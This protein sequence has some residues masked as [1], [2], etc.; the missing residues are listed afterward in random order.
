MHFPIFLKRPLVSSACV[1][2]VRNEQDI[3]E[4]F[5]RHN[6]RFFDFMLILDHASTDATRRILSQLSNELGNVLVRDIADPAQRQGTFVTDALHRLSKLARP[7]IVAFLDADEFIGVDDRHDFLKRFRKLRVGRGYRLPWKTLIPDPQAASEGELLDRF[8]LVR[9]RDLPSSYKVLIRLGGRHYPDL[10]IAQGNHKAHRDRK[11][12]S[13]P[14]LDTPVIFHIPVRNSEQIMAKGVLSWAAELERRKHKGEKAS[15]GTAGQWRMLHEQYQA[16][17]RVATSE[18]LAAI[19]TSYAQ[20]ECS[21]DWRE[22]TSSTD[23]RLKRPRRYSDGTSLPLE[24]LVARK[25]D[26]MRQLQAEADQFPTLDLALLRGVSDLLAPAKLKTYCSDD[27]TAADYILVSGS[28]TPKGPPASR[29]TVALALDIAALSPP[30]LAKLQASDADTLLIAASGATAANW[31]PSKRRFLKMVGRLRKSGWNV[32][33]S[34]SLALR[35]LSDLPS[36]SASA[37]VMRRYAC[38]GPALKLFDSQA[39][40]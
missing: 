39:F 32:D 29:R 20:T 25:A 24:E 19:A 31:R 27:K 10:R 12:I 21:S 1:C 8:G 3:I 26:R 35:V 9:N 13:A 37:L 40:S 4:P 16:G 18:Q 36:H 38:R 22:R 23:L 30:A 34:L 15:A 33:Q 2:M 28:E 14:K 11:R 6:T 17:D 7:D 5:V